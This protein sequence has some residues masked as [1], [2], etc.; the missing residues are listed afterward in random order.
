MDLK[1][2]EVMVTEEFI[3]DIKKNGKIEGL[4]NGDIEEEDGILKRVEN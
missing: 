3:E 4:K 1:E 2:I